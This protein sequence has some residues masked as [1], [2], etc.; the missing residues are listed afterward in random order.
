MNAPVSVDDLNHE[1]IRNWLERALRGQEPLPLLTRDEFPHLGILRLE[2]TLKPATRDSLRDGALQLVRRFCADGLGETAYLEE[3]LA[4]ASAFRDS[5]AVQMLARLAEHFPDASQISTEI[6]LAVL[7]ALVDMSPPQPAEFWER[8]FRQDPEQ[9]A[10][11]VLSGMLA[12]DPAACAIEL[13]PRMPDTERAGQAAALKLDLAW[14]DLPPE[15]RHRFVQNIQ[16]VLTR[17]GSRF[18]GPVRAWANSKIAPRGPEANPGLWAALRKSL[19]PEV[20]PRT[21]T[22]KLC[23]AA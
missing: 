6:R 23:E 22:P 17:C 12:I 2:K 16:A 9:Y 8:I 3:L 10:G 7:A 4:L 20:A 5:E 15:Q 1:E 11:L 13:L 18:V 19:G 14:D 21:H